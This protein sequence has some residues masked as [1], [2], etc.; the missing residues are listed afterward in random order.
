MLVMFSCVLLI[1]MRANLCIML[2][3]VQYVIF[4]ASVSYGTT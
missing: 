2:P 1:Q 4:A 3:V